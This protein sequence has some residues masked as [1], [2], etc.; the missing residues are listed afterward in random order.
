MKRV[1]ILHGG[2]EIRQEDPTDESGQGVKLSPLPH[3]AR[4]LSSTQPPGCRLR[5]IEF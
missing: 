4:R 3:P 1:G 2:V 5:I